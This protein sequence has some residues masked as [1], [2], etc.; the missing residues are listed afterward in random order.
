MLADEIQ[1]VADARNVKEGQ[2]LAYVCRIS[3]LPNS[4]ARRL[5]CPIRE[6]RPTR[7]WAFD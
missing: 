1:Q 6:H 3:V 7:D 4:L 2:K 5:A